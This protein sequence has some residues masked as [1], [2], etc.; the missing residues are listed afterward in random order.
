MSY[1]AHLRL[2]TPLEVG[3]LVALY[4]LIIQET[5]LG[6]IDQDAGS[7]ARKHALTA[8]FIMYICVSSRVSFLKADKFLLR[9]RKNYY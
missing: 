2:D 9:V 3:G 1:F 4:H 6:G 8:I 5:K 7:Y